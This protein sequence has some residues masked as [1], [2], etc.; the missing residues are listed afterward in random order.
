MTGG[1][2]LWPLFVGVFAILAVASVVGWILSARPL[3]DEGRRTVDNL[4]ARIRA[5][6]VM[7]L[8]FGL[9]FL[10]GRTVTLVLFALTSFWALREFI[11]LTPTR[12]SDHTAI[13]VAFYVFIP[14]QY[15]LIWFDYTGMFLVLI[16]V[17]G[18]LLLP[19]LAVL[20]GETDNFPS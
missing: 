13:S 9:A 17:Y 1:P 19:V 2:P 8:L 10:A 11:T 5:W 15:V 4:N 20:K 18:Y 12:P 14:L 7:V 3:S 16:P 6:W